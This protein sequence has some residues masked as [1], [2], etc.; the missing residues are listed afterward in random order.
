MRRAAESR[1]KADRERETAR[2]TLYEL[3]YL[4]TRPVTSGANSVPAGATPPA[5]VRL[6]LSAVTQSLVRSLDHFLSRLDRRVLQPHQSGEHRA[7][8]GDGSSVSPLDVAVSDAAAQDELETRQLINRNDDDDP[9]VPDVV[10]ERELLKEFKETDL[11]LPEDLLRLKSQ[12][13]KTANAN[14][15]AKAKGKKPAEPSKILPTAMRLQQQVAQTNKQRREAKPFCT[16]VFN[17]S[18]ND[19]P[20]YAT[21]QPQSAGVTRDFLQTLPLPE[22]WN[23]KES[24]T[25]LPIKAAPRARAVFQLVWSMVLFVLQSGLFIMLGVDDTFNHQYPITFT[26][27][28]SLSMWADSPNGRHWMMLGFMF[29]LRML[30]AFF[31]LVIYVYF[32]AFQPIPHILWKPA[33]SEYFNANQESEDSLRAEHEEETKQWQLHNFFWLS[34][35]IAEGAAVVAVCTAIGQTELMGLCAAFVAVFTTFTA[36]TILDAYASWFTRMSHGA[37]VLAIVITLTCMDAAVSP[38]SLHR[39][40]FYLWL[41]FFV[42]QHVAFHYLFFYVPTM[43]L[44][45]ALPYH[46]L[47]LAQITDYLNRFLR[48][49]PKSVCDVSVDTEGVHVPSGLRVTQLPYLIDDFQ[50]TLAR[51]VTDPVQDVTYEWLSTAL[52]TNY[53][54]PACLTCPILPDALEHAIPHRR[55][56]R[57]ALIGGVCFYSAF[58]FVCAVAMSLEVG[59]SQVNGRV[60]VRYYQEEQSTGLWPVAP[61]FIFVSWLANVAFAA[62]VLLRRGEFEHYLKQIF[63]QGACSLRYL[64]LAV[65]DIFQFLLYLHALGATDAVEIVMF[66]VC[67]S[68]AH[69]MTGSWKHQCAHAIRAVTTLFQ[70]LPWT[71]LVVRAFAIDGDIVEHRGRRIAVALFAFVVNVGETLAVSLSIA[72]WLDEH[73]SLNYYIE[74]G[75]QVLRA[76]STCVGTLLVWQL[77][78][79]EAR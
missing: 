18:A 65:V 23:F 74:L 33:E 32:L 76:L 55:V 67:I 21:Q 20:V 38:S 68:I 3:C 53:R 52:V 77:E 29:L 64:A 71:A 58:A 79:L 44:L 61:M 35:G 26:N 59:N 62:F 30:V 28:R 66:A 40:V 13:K 4:K 69:W 39:T 45:T 75:W 63:H 7:K 10:H 22:G 19:T 70:L 48:R 31:Q 37:Y 14:A 24:S 34:Q 56:L 11:L 12:A 73:P 9:S 43:Y 51:T 2:V 16:A 36:Y 54:S 5:H 41:S 15:K 57:S 72:S 47:Y 17:W 6:Q 8:R 49:A 1:S 50:Q 42:L 25:S 46:E 27:G 60:S 78:L